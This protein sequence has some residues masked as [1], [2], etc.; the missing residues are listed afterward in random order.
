[1]TARTPAVAPPWT[2]VR[3]D[4][5]MV[6]MNREL[7]KQQNPLPPPSRPS[8]LHAT[9]NSASPSSSAM[10]NGDGGGSETRWWQMTAATAKVEAVG[11][12]FFSI[13]SIL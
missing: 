10:V 8:L 9:M 13:S 1:M 5:K 11:A 6:V 3:K 7:Q 2:A 4:S 12:T